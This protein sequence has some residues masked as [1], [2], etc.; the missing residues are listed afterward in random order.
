PLRATIRAVDERGRLLAEQVV[1]VPAGASDV[2]ARIDPPWLVRQGV[3]VRALIGPPGGTWAGRTARVVAFRPR[4]WSRFWFTSWGGTEMWRSQYLDDFDTRLVS[5]YGIDVSFWGITELG[6]GRVRNNAYFGVNMSWLGLLGYLGGKSPEFADPEFA[7]KARQYAQT[8]DKQ[9]LVRNP[10]LVDPEWREVVRKNLVARASRT[11][12]WGGT[13]DYCMGDEMSLT[14]YTQYLDFDW[15]PQSLSDFRRW[16]QKRYAAVDELNAAWGTRFAGWDE[17]VPQTLDEAKAAANPAA[18]AEFRTYM[19]D[20]IADFYRFVQDTLRGVDPHAECGLS[21]TQSPE[22]GNGMDW[23]KVGQAFS[24][25]HSYNT[26]WSSEM[27]RSWQRYGLAAQSPYNAGYS[28]VN[29]GAEY[30]LWWCLFH[31]TRGIS[32]W[33]TGLFFQ[34]DFDLSQSGRDT[35]THLDAFKSGVWRLLRGAQRQ[36]DGIALHYSMPSILAGALMGQEAKLNAARDAWVK[37]LEDLGLQYEFVSA[38]QVT[39]GL[40][41]QEGYKVLVLP[42]DVAISR[43]EADQLRAFVAGGGTLLAGR[44]IGQRDELCRPQAPGLLDDLFGVKLEGAEQAVEPKV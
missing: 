38:E 36:H 34:G 17:V 33:K 19:N 5:D 40:L 30:N 3:E 29:P 1:P 25:F 6:T 4:V 23:W 42:Y 22:A 9:Y 39:A 18:W 35:K 32:A 24:Y 20:Q 43:A 10:S 2:A 11:T 21:G 44:P 15:S 14:Y 37:L 26:S 16:L 41:K 28:A 13:Y 7:T 31:D 12:D 27:R 8:K